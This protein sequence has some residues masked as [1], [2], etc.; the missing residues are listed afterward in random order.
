MKLKKRKVVYFEG[1]DEYAEKYFGR[2][3]NPVDFLNE[4]E[5]AAKIF[6]EGSKALEE[7]LLL[8]WKFGYCTKA[9]CKGHRKP[10][11]YIKMGLFKNSRMSAEEYH[12][13]KNGP[14]YKRP[15]GYKMAPLFALPYISLCNLPKKE[16]ENLKE[17]LHKNLKLPERLPV[18]FG[19]S[20]LTV[21][22]DNQFSN[23]TGEIDNEWCWEEV[24]QTFQ[25]YLIRDEIS[26]KTDLKV[27]LEKSKEAEQ[28]KPD[29]T[30]HKE[31]NTKTLSENKEYSISK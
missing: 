20:E 18:R 24:L 16:L 1:I 31:K 22:F 30:D 21:R 28:S 23:K 26:W 4:R 19:E 7:L 9:C 27:D 25:N 12:K 2:A 17:F 13:R 14:W 15:R 29:R 11:E 3:I 8:V 5:K 6:A 10:E